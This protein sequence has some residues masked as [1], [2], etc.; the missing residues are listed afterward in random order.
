MEIRTNEL[1]FLQGLVNGIDLKN[2]NDR[3]LSLSREQNVTT[4][5]RFQG[6]V[7]FRNTLETDKLTLK[8]LIKVP[9][10]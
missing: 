10:R 6:T 3:Y 9:Q 8:G 5:L 4:P 2:L 1:R 7:H